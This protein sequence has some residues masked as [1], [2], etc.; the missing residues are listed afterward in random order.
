MRSTRYSIL[1]GSWPT[2]RG[3]RLSSITLQTASGAP[4]AKASPTPVGPPSV[5]TRTTICLRVA[6]VHGDGGSSGFIGRARQIASIAVIFMAQA[7]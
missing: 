6:A 2:R 4:Y 7:P 5:F 1:R 3:A